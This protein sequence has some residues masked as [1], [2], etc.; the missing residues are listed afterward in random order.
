M[1]YYNP[2][3]EK[4]MS[5]NGLKNKLNVSFPKGEEQVEDWY[6][7]HNDTFPKVEGTQRIVQDTIVLK[8]GKYYQTFKVGEKPLTK[9][10]IDNNS[11][12]AALEEGV[13][14]LAKLI[15]EKL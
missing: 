5:Y 13:A 10:I 12:I 7:L 9:T 1:I 6:L 3:T 8:D 4:K 15:A 11:R 14:E 2:K